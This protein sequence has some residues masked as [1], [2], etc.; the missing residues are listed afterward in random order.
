M[1]ITLIL[2]ISAA[3]LGGQTSAQEAPP[4]KKPRAS[5]HNSVV[6]SAGLSKKELA[7]E[8]HVR[9]ILDQGQSAL[10]HREFQAALSH[11]LSA[12]D[13]AGE[14]TD[15]KGG[16]RSEAL[17]NA[18]R[19]YAQ[20]GRLDEAEQTYLRLGEALLE[21]GGPFESSIGHNYLDLAALRMQRGDW[22]KAKHY[23]L[24]AIKTYDASVEHF[25]KPDPNEDFIAW[26]VRRSKVT[27]LY[28]LAVI[29][30]RQ[31]KEDL[32]LTTLE[33]AY[34]LGTEYQARREVLGRIIRGALELLERR[35]RPEE[36]QRWRQ[37]EK[38]W[39]DS[40]K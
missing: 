21:W 26:N 32:A 12:A 37:R 27:G 13:L 4:K 14:L 15:R 1:S 36:I 16:F 30:T 20:L 17:R 22:A 29:Y 35:A 6:V 11:F 9:R 7:K 23:T 2:T 25:A 33:E 38:A 31:A 5:I 8:E 24:E 34:N 10:A 19:C 28:Y 18:A 40:A 3:L 39:L